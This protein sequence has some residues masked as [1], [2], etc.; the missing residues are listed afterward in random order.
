MPRINIDSTPV[1]ENAPRQ[2]VTIAGERY[3]IPAPYAAGH[4]LTAAEAAV[5]NQTFAENVRNNVAAKMKKLAEDNL[6]GLSAQDV[7]DYALCYT[8]EQR[9]TRGPRETIDPIDREVTR[10]A[11]LAVM[12]SLKNKGRKLKDVAD[13][14]EGRDAWLAAAVA[15]VIELKGDELRAQAETILNARK[16]ASVVV[17]ELPS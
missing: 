5:L 1:W 7:E 15:R 10:L 9:N 11:T 13:T 14:D 3:S 16:A 12:K 6:P 4:V 8:F 2:M 17:A